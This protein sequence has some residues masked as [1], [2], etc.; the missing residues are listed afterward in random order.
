MLK[1]KEKKEFEQFLKMLDEDRVEA[2]EK[3][4]AL[5]KR[6]E[7]FFEWRNCENIEELTT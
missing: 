1:S 2:A 6:L 7:K 5:R 4:L 3:Y